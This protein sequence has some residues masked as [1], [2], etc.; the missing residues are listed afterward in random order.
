MPN[1][2]VEV[3]IF[4][5][6]ERDVIDDVINRYSDYS[7][8]EISEKSHED[9]PW[10]ITKDMDIIS[11]D[12]VGKREYPYSPHARKNKKKDT[13]Q[14]A[15]ITGFFDDLAHEPDAYEEYR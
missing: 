12:L 7:A 14:F 2:R 15:K 11:Y 4:S 10:K 13:Q 5:D 9:I 6:Q 3:E 8:T 1:R